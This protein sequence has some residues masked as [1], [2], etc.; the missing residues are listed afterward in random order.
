MRAVLIFLLWLSPAVGRTQAAATLVADD[1]VVTAQ[2]QLIATGNVEVFYDG[3]RLVAQSITYDSATDKLTITGP[4]IVTTS[5]GVIV[6]ATQATLDPRLKNGIL[7]GARL[8]LNRQLQ[9]SAD[10]I[11]RSQGRYSQLYKVAVT[12]C[13]VC[14]GQSPLWEIRARAVV[15]DAQERQLYF[16]G[17]QFR[18]KG[19]PVAYIPRIRLPDPTLARTTGLLLPRLRTTN[20][21]GLGLKLPYFVTLGDHRDLKLTP[22]LSTET[23]T[24]ELRYRQ[25]FANGDIHLDAAASQDTLFDGSRNYVMVQ[26]D[27]SVANGYQL[28]FDIEAAS[29]KNYL[30][31]YGYSDKDRLDS[32]L[33]L[34]KIQDDRYFS[35]G[36]TYFQTLRDDEENATL[37][38][39]IGDIQYE[40]RIDLDHW[41]VFDIGAS[42]DLAYRYSD[43]DGDAGR[44][45]GRIGAW[46]DWQHHWVSGG[47][48]ARAQAGLMADYYRINNDTS[49][50]QSGL[51]SSPHLA[52]R[53]DYPLAM[54]TASGAQHL[55]T[56][57]V[58]VAWSDVDGFAAPN[59]DSTR[60]ELDET[61]LFSL[62]RFGGQDAVETGLR[63]AIGASW[64]RLGTGGI[65]ST[66][67]MGRIIREANVDGFTP[68]SGMD[69]ADSDWLIAG[70]IILPSGTSLLARTRF[71]EDAHLTHAE[72]LGSWHSQTVDLTAAYLWQAADASENRPSDLSEITLDTTVKLTDHWAISADTRYDL[73][74]GK[75]ARAGLGVE[76]K[77]ECVTV[78]LSAA[79]R[80]ADAS[81]VE[82]ETSYGLSVSLTGFST[83][84]SVANSAASCGP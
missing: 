60:S 51:R 67:S 43:V 54:T 2:D 20:K 35:T 13:Q 33:R 76:Y 16:E 74:N 65:T 44:D 73:T 66:L 18:I 17:A 5:Q 30:L 50:A 36:L 58:A 31:D 72:A 40:R 41:G 77:N 27:F 84:R 83:G 22:Y 56:P 45:V 61:N 25:A 10:Y 80:Y 29:D 62:N 1:V 79:R 71:D 68:S 64:T 4:I 14:Q 39:L 3:I 38:P 46:F 7:Q 34:E 32:A 11:A 26:G 28:R 24:I 53:L 82:P 47:V 48:L 57:T 78:G 37:P 8:V 69:A 21:L 6:T 49:F 75:P 42:A 63:A 55:V 12:S 81:T 52:L 70:Q 59:E 9:L 23:K 19:V 15:H